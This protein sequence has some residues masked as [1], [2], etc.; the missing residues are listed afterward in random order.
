[1]L[2]LS[3]CVLL[4][5]CTSNNAS[6][7]SSSASSASSGTP[8]SPVFHDVSF[9]SDAAVGD[10]TA[11]IDLSQVSDG[12]IGASAKSDI[13]L[14][15]LVSRGDQTYNYDLPGTGEPII[16]PVNMG[17]GTYTVRIMQNTSADRYVELLSAEAD[18]TLSDE[19]APFVRPNV[20]CNYDSESEAVKLAEKLCANATTESEAFDAVYDYITKNIGYDYE[21][22]S[23][24]ADATGYTPNPDETLAS[25][26]GICFDYASLTAA[27]LRSQGIATKI[28]TGYVA[29]DNVYH[30][31]DMIY[32]DGSWLSLHISAQPGQWARADM[33]FAANGAEDAI[34]N[35]SDY[36]DRYTY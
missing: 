22:A 26:K 25:G 32:I 33:T 5:G 34:G 3:L 12:I 31:W 11:R 20:I 27:M 1:M 14:K 4:A 6:P 7:A 24:L 35:G 21:K 16:A 18:I 28:L 30:A 10:E 17:D 36:A 29:P 19:N 2:A 23:E 13:R 9:N 8:F 15:L